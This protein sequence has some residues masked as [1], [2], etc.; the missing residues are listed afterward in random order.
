MRIE[1][2]GLG[3]GVAIVDVCPGSTQTD[4][5]RNS[6]VSGTDER[7]VSSDVNI[8]NGL[9]VDYVAERMIATAVAR[10]P[11]VWLAKGPE[12]FVCYLSH[13]FPGLW[14]ILSRLVLNKYADE[15]LEVKTD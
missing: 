3:S 8:D 11:V 4:V 15:I 6:F 13:Y 9:C 10:T 5:A 1:E 2:H 12:L 14:A 7:R